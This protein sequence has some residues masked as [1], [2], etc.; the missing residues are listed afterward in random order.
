MR[1]THPGARRPRKTAF[2]AIL[3]VFAMTA[4][5]TGPRLAF[6]QAKTASPVE[7]KDKVPLPLK[8]PK[9][10]F[11]GT[12]SN[13]TAGPTVEKLTGKPRPVPLVPKGTVNLALHKKVT[14]SSAPFSGS[15]DLV[16]DGDKEARE[17]TAVELKPRLQWIQIDLGASQT[18]FYVV[19]WHFHLEPIVYHN[20]IVQVS[21]DPKFIDGV[22]TLFNNDQDNT[23]GLGIGKDREYFE[24]NEG[25]L[26]DA[27]G[28]KARYVRLYSKGSTYRD[29]LNRYTEVEVYG[30]PSK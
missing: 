21:D 7:D 9:A 5:L 29:P 24:T 27:K 3:C 12:A 26:I 8:L 20:V 4:G 1:G 10:V 6:C 22:K 28:V 23:A 18:L 16:T 14:S 11:A 30:L 25:K 15:L 19:V 13:T 2:C 17:D